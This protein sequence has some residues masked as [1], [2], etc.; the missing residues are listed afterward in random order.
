MSEKE[1]ERPES[2]I[3]VELD[4]ASN[5]Q[6]VFQHNRMINTGADRVGA[7]WEV[8]CATY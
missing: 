7:K 5:L 1:H 6:N 2:Q 4:A 3:G 8:T